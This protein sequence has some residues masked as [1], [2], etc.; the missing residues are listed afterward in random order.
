[1]GKRFDFASLA[2]LELAAIVHF[3]GIIDVDQ[4]GSGGTPIEILLNI[5]IMFGCTIITV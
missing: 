3:E 2:R 4:H 5:V 1:M